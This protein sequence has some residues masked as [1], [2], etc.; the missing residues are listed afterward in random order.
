MAKQ[1]DRD[2]KLARIQAVFRKLDPYAQQI[3]L[4]EIERLTQLN[5]ERKRLGREPDDTIN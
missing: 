2:T 3:V 1:P 5:Q 4:D